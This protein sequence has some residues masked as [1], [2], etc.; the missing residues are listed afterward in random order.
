MRCECS[1]AQNSHAEG[2]RV[3]AGGSVMDTTLNLFE[4]ILHRARRLQEQGRTRDAEQ[5]YHRLAQFG[6]LPTDIAAET[7]IHLAE[8]SLRRGRYAL[9]RRHLRAALSFRPNCARSHFLLARTLLGQQQSM[10]GEV[11][12]LEHAA[13]HLRRALALAPDNVRYR[14]EMGLLDLRQGNHH[15]ALPLLRETAKQ[16]Q[17]QSALI[18]RLVKGLMQLEQT[19]EAHSILKA[20][21]FRHSRSPRI[22]QL[23]KD[24]ELQLLG[25]MRQGRGQRPRKDGTMSA[26][27]DA[28]ILPYI[29][30]TSTQRVR[31]NSL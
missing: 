6:E 25:G 21:Q 8:L 12:D 13:E 22:R 18:V 3:A 17:D 20:A 10:P 1:E 2:F 31:T 4:H 29:P 14:C 26:A 16:A 5:L 30:R 15:T 27:T 19:E 7:Q 23:A 28:I 24:I 9:A 11:E